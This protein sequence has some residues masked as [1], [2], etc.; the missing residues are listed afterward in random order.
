VNAGILFLWDTIIV[1]VQK[2]ESVELI[3]QPTQSI[4]RHSEASSI[5]TENG[6]EERIKLQLRIL[7][8]VLEPSVKFFF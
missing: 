4:F 1:K 7:R 8:E 5:L 2:R 3:H 6:D